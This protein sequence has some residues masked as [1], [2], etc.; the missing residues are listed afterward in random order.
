MA[1]VQGPGEGPF[2]IS[3]R[4]KIQYEKEYRAGVDLF[5]RALEQ[6]NS[7]DEPYK[8][9]AFKEVMDRAMQV[10]NETA[11]ELKRADLMDQNQKISQS[12]EALQ[13]QKTDATIVANN[14]KQAK[15]NV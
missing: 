15:K 1:N 8:K 10:L 13:D 14:L 5:Q 9:E 4:D 7:T 6:Y 11:R 3:H 2:P 12:F